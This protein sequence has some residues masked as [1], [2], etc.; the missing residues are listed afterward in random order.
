MTSKRTKSTS[1][2]ANSDTGTTS[3][4]SARI[5]N[6]SK[7]VKNIVKDAADILDEEVASGIIAARQVQDRFKREN[8]IDPKDFESALQKF[9]ADAHEVLT[10]VGKQIDEMGSK[11]NAELTRRL[12]GRTHDVLDL[13][14]EIVN[15]GAA[16]AN[17]LIQKNTKPPEAGSAANGK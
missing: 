15:I 3:A 5:K 12:M 6:A 4:H 8:K 13:T 17:E 14:I 9:N 11:E 2:Q 1:G 16:L 10:M 7:S